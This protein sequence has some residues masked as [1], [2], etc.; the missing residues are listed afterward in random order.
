MEEDSNQTD[1]SPP[2]RNLC[3]W[4]DRPFTTVKYTVELWTKENFK[5]PAYLCCRQCLEQF[6]CKKY[7]YDLNPGE[8]YT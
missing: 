8:R 1:L 7:R 5:T 2:I 4:C 3:F 6:R